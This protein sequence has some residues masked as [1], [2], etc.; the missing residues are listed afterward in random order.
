MTELSVP[1]E[2]FTLIE[3]LV[4]LLLFTVGL[5]GY[6]SLQLTVQRFHWEIHQRIYAVNLASYMANQVESNPIAQGCYNLGSVEVGSGQEAMFQCV[7]LGTLAT[8]D[9]AQADVNQWSALLRGEGQMVDKLNSSG[10]TN[11][12]GCITFDASNNG[13]LVTVVWQG[14]TATV[15]TLGRCGDGFYG[16]GDNRWRRATQH[17]V[18][19]ASLDG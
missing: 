13:Y 11:A 2:G 9:L 4:S 8:R 17:W 15:A 1:A 3:V 12:R 6:A 14:L 5:L 18:S 10:L 16:E 19:V 7:G